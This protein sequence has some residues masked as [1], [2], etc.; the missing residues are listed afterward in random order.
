MKFLQDILRLA[1][2]DK[3]LTWKDF[4]QFM[5][6][7]IPWYWGIVMSILVA[8]ATCEIALSVDN[9]HKKYKARR[10]S[11]TEREKYWRDAVPLYA[12]YKEYQDRAGVWYSNRR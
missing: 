2:S 4:R 10:A 9:C 12:G 1:N 5:S 7:D 8:M 6:S 11:T 3:V